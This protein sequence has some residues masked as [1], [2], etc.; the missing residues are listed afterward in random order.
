MQGL[1]VD[2]TVDS[3]L[4]DFE[5]APLSD[6]IVA[7]PGVGEC[8]ASSRIVLVAADA[9]H[10]LRMSRSSGKTVPHRGDAFFCGCG[11]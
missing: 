7:C 10:I 2:P 3:D 4:D 1:H 11:P 5:E 8:G 9:E 6:G